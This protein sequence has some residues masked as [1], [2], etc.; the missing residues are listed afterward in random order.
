MSRRDDT[1]TPS[2]DELVAGEPLI[3]SE[4]TV[5]GLDLPPVDPAVVERLLAQVPD[6][7]QHRDHGA[8]M[9]LRLAVKRE[10]EPGLADDQTR[11][12]AALERDEVALDAQADTDRRTA[13]GRVDDPGPVRTGPKARA[14]QAGLGTLS[15]VV[16]AVLMVSAW[17]PTLGA[18]RE[19][20]DGVSWTWTVVVGLLVS[21]GCAALLATPALMARPVA[22]DW[23]RGTGFGLVAIA[24]AVLLASVLFRLSQGSTV[25]R[26]VLV[27]L[28][29]LAAVPVVSLAAWLLLRERTSPQERRAARDAT[30]AATALHT[31]RVEELEVRLDQAIERLTSQVSEH[32]SRA[33]LAVELA[34]LRRLYETG[35]LTPEAAG[36]SAAEAARYWGTR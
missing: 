30:T 22:P 15:G 34:G 10:L 12:E 6:D 36:M 5:G 7:E 27:Q 14:H 8:A 31:A 16:L 2:W 33:T 28:V 17:L 26:D 9:R 35:R 4:G 20:F 1:A 13:G 23:K 3:G 18:M 19:G 24:S 25:E 32:N 21:L 29:L 11:L